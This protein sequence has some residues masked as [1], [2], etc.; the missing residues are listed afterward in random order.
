MLG[1][2]ADVAIGVQ[3]IQ[4]LSVSGRTGPFFGRFDVTP[5]PHSLKV[6]TSCHLEP[7]ATMAFTSWIQRLISLV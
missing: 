7:A 5:S 1:G 4:V 6:V 3:Y 2:R